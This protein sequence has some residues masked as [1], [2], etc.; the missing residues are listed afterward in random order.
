MKITKTKRFR[1][2]EIKKKKKM[3]KEND[4]N[5]ISLH[6]DNLLTLMKKKMIC[7]KIKRFLTK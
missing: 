2:H 3:K 7:I 5:K 1:I 6:L 4:S